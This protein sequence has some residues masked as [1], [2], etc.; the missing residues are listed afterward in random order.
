MSTNER[1][2]IRTIVKWSKPAVIFTVALVLLAA[3]VFVQKAYAQPLDQVSH[4]LN[5]SQQEAIKIKSNLQE[6]K[7]QKEQ[8]AT[9]VQ[10][11][12]QKISQLEQENSE[13]KE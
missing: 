11:K 12:E 6:V 13:L 7:S 1:T 3:Y 4:S 8:L 10:T 9:E 2:N 5:Q